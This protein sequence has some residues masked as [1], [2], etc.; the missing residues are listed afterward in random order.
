MKK[1]INILLLFLIVFAGCK[2]KKTDEQEIQKLLDRQAQIQESQ[3]E[4]LDELQ[5]LKDSLAVEKEKLVMERDQKDEKVKL[6]E[7]NQQ[8]LVEELKKEE[9]TDI[10]SEKGKLQ[11][12]I[13]GYEDSIKQLKEELSILDADIDSIANTMGLYEVQEEQAEKLHE[14]GIDEI[15]QR[16][17]KLENQKQQEI[18]KADLLDRRI[19]ISEKKIEA[20]QMEREMYVDERD[21]LLRNNASEEKLEPYR[22]KIAEMDS[23]IRVEEKNKQEII[24]ELNETKQWISDVDTMINDLQTK[25][26]QEYDKRNIIEGFISSEKERLQHEIDNLKTSRAKLVNEQG[27]ISDELS[28]I[29]KKI[30]SLNKKMELIKDKDMSD[31]LEQQAE[32]EQ[33]EAA[34]AEEEARLMEESRKIDTQSIRVTSEVAGEELKS[35]VELGNQI[36]SLRASV[37]EEKAE[38]AKTRKELSEKRAEAAQKRAKFGRTLVTLIIIIV[39]GGLGLLTLFYYL[40]KR[41]RIS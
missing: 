18:K 17:N 23:I 27:Q 11:E 21:E 15:D 1:L 28:G 16:I 6:L 34:L 38:I 35:L 2:T 29:E 36:D 31:L 40:G 10:S 24:N 14:S 9:E 25:I 26:K 20:Y 19:L 33:S 41:A 4:S 22:N 3:K 12:Q 7:K 5:Q 30:A 32:I 8:I 37:K 39:V 13:S